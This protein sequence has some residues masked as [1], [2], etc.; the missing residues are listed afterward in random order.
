MRSTRLRFALAFSVL[1]GAAVLVS[2]GG[3]TQRLAIADWKIL[4]GPGKVTYDEQIAYRATF[5]TDSKSTLNKVTALMTIPVAEDPDGP[6]VE[7]GPTPESHTCPSEPQIVPVADGP[8][9]WIC[10]FG[11]VVAGADELVLTVV[12][13][14]PTL[15]RQ[16]ICTD[17][18]ETHV[19]WLMKEG[20]NDTTDPNDTPVDKMLFAT[21]LPTGDIPE[22]DGE[23]LLAGGYETAP[24]SC[25]GSSAGNLKTQGALGAENK[26]ITTV[27]FPTDVFPSAGESQDTGYATFLTETPGNPRHT[28]VCIAKLGTDCA[29][30]YED[31]NFFVNWGGKKITV[32]ILAF[33][34]KKPEITTVKHN[35]VPMTAQTCQAT[36]DCVVSITYNNPGKFYR[37]EVTSGSNGF[38]DF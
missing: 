19:K 14:A 36:G 37:I 28:D 15:E 7:A 1:V 23:T 12:W 4:P 3:A 31:E 29:P 2:G 33:V 18:L 30:G 32:V 11:T 27:C 20:P 25:A 35:D 8:D 24:S 6:D 10:N 22:D 9:Q 16:T 13:K 17:C 38:Y 5:K 21:L 34:P 26:I